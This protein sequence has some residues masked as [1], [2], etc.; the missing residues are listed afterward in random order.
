MKRLLI[1]TVLAISFLLLGCTDTYNGA[2]DKVTGCSK[3]QDKAKRDFC[4]SNAAQLRNDITLCDYIEVQVARGFCY[5]EL[6]KINKNLSTCDSVQKFQMG[7]IF[8]Q[9]SMKEICYAYI[10]EIEQNLDICKKIS[11]PENIGRCY[12]RIGN[13]SSG[14]SCNLL[15]EGTA[16]DI[17]FYEIKWLT[18]DEKYCQEISDS[19]SREICENG[20]TIVKIA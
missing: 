18:K 20:I 13:A 12:S 5:T 15:M 9:T 10:A 1:I 6:A 14:G 8:N 4:F 16:R 17:C 2:N 3:I 11:A 7:D 19:D